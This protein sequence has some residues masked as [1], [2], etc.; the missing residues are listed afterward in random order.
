VDNFLIIFL[1][2]K[3]ALKIKVFIKTPNLDVE[4]SVDKIVD[5]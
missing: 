4:K 1:K 5:K 2:I 3:K